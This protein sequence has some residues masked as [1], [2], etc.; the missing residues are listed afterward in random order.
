M[1]VKIKSISTKLV[2]YF[3]II[4]L[5]SSL[6][7][8]VL[9]FVSSTRGM[10]DI[11]SQML[12]DKL[13]GDIASA[14]Q[15]LDN[16][17][18]YMGVGDGTLYDES[19]KSIEGRNEMVDAISKD[20]GDVA[21]LFVR[22]GDNFRRI[23]S[24]VM[25]I[26]NER[27]V[28]TLLDTQSP[29]YAAV[30]N[31]ETYIGEVN[32]L[33]A[34]YYSA[35]EPIK[36]PEGY[37]IGILYVG[38]PKTASENFIKSHSLKQGITSFVTII[39]ILL[40]ALVATFFM[41]RGLANP[42][43]YVS[44]E[45]EKIARYN[46]SI[47]DESSRLDTLAKGT[48]EIATIAGSVFRLHK[49]LRHIVTSVSD[50]SHTV[51]KSADQL[52]ATSEQSSLALDDVARAVDEIARGASDQ[53]LDTEKAAIKA[54][55]IG[56]LINANEINIAELNNSAA[57]IDKQKEEGFQILEELVKTTE[58]NEIAS[59][60]IFEIIRETNENAHRIENA[61]EMIQSIADQTNLLALNAA[62]ESARAG[63]AGRG[64]AVVAEEIRK[65]AEESNGFTKEI[66]TVINE[67]KSRTQE[68]VITMG[69]TEEIV[70]DQGK[71]VRDTGDKFRMIA[72][73]IE[74][75]RKS[76]NTIS[77]SEGEINTKIDEL[78]GIVQSLSAIAE[79]NAAGTEE[80][81]AAIEEQTAGM[82][83]IA[84]SSEQLAGMAEELNKLVDRFKI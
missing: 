71:G 51:G 36:N 61:S 39:V 21:T 15:Y 20:L 78:I 49:N 77:I 68:A 67:L 38:V 69:K 57:E 73:A 60:E 25:S 16:F 66:N 12:M 9:G 7:V 3:G 53:A 65:L 41:G 17:Y 54:D 56:Q 48:D 31:G 42:I 55:E 70:L 19:G 28:G 62:I 40:I 14:E 4:I 64:F 44:R 13:R 34:D 5:L 79:E 81:S 84:N 46:L 35:Y 32:I 58:E 76:I 74:D 10:K 63:E 6:T 29:A 8:G 82:E 59:K 22:D 11:Q 37:P 50:T 24:N 72:S 45:V 27:A 30:I 83:E 26:E 47:D 43:V 80:S 23:S 75:T 1:A 18:G 2:V 33:G 52:S